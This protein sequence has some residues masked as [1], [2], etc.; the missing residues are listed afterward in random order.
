MCGYS[1]YSH[2][3]LDNTLLDKPEYVTNYLQKIMEALRPWAN[4]D[5]QLMQTFKNRFLPNSKNRPVA[6]WDLAI[7]ETKFKSDMSV[8]LSK[9]LLIVQ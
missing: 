8:K 6:P 3:A 1:S 9:S 5:I 7:L 2:R 4:R